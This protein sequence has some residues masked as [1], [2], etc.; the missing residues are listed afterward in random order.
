MRLSVFALLLLAAVFGLTLAAGAGLEGEQAAAGGTCPVESCTWTGT[1]S[2]LIH[3]TATV[4][5]PPKVSSHIYDWVIVAT[6]LVFEANS[7]QPEWTLVGGTIEWTFSGTRTSASG[8]HT[9]RLRR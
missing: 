6:D 8:S 1:A 7:T 2:V 5:Q 3:D 9:M 4:N